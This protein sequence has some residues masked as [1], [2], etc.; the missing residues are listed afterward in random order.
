M[1]YCRYSELNGK[2]HF[3]P[4]EWFSWQIQKKVLSTRWDK[5][6]I[7]I[8]MQ[9]ALRKGS[10]PFSCNY[11]NII[12][13]FISI[14]PIS[15]HIARALRLRWHCNACRRQFVVCIGA[16]SAI[17][18]IRYAIVCTWGGFEDVYAYIDRL[19]LSATA[20]SRAKPLKCWL[21]G[22]L[23]I[24]WPPL[25]LMESFNIETYA[26]FACSFGSGTNSNFPL[27]GVNKE[28]Q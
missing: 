5:I 7:W 13:N 8:C 18:R 2:E 9:H 22:R 15:M 12:A 17:I 25:R 26:L 1:Y 3:R 16:S 10:T 27:T 11:S 23:T 21:L 6:P 14:K 20:G 28:N 19:H 24:P 4:S